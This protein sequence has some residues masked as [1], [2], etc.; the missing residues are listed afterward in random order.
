[1]TFKPSASGARCRVTFHKCK[2][3]S[4]HLPRRVPQAPGLSIFPL[5]NYHD[6]KSNAKI[7][8]F[9]LQDWGGKN[10]TYP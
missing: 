4:S 10:M 3:G 9:N 2:M 6:I 1:M 7:F 5:I 8:F